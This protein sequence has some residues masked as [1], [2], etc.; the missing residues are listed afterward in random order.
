MLKP[1]VLAFAIAA[2]SVPAAI[3]GET[4]VPTPVDATLMIF[5]VSAVPRTIAIE[6]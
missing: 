5:A 2:L 3:A 6:S 4:K 1:S